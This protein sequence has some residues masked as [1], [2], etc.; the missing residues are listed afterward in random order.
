[1]KENTL[2]CAPCNTEMKLVILPKYEFEEGC[3][4][5]HV[6]TYQ[7]PSCKDIFFTEEQSDAMEEMTDEIQKKSFGFERKV[8]ISGKSLA[9]TIPTDLAGHLHIKAGTKVRILPAKGG[10]TVKTVSAR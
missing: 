5:F 3:P 1:M 10:F 9:V 8:T 4:I 2:Y 7:C 6:P